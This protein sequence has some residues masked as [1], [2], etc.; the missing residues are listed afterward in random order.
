M[1]WRAQE[2]WGAVA[3]PTRPAR[4]HL[5]RAMKPDRA[6]L[7]AYNLFCAAL[8]GLIGVWSLPMLSG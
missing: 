2:R 8:L 4:A 6:I 1:R 7:L 3:L 5:S